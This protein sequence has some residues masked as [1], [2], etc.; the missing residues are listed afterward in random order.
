MGH[1]LLDTERLIRLRE[2]RIVFSKTAPENPHQKAAMLAGRHFILML[3]QSGP[4]VVQRLLHRCLR[5]G[6]PVHSRS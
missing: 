1:E 5:S 6:C 4:L 2:G 3:D